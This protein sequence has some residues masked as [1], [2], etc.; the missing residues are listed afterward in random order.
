MTSG[1]RKPWHTTK[2]SADALRDEWG[3]VASTFL[4]SC[5]NTHSRAW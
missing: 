3:L 5:W 1:A 4:N 2:I